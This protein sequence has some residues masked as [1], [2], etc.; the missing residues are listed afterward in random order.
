AFDSAS[1]FLCGKPARLERRRENQEVGPTGRGWY[2]P[3][4]PKA[5][6]FRSTWLIIGYDAGH[7]FLL[8]FRRRA[9]TIPPRNEF[10][11]TGIRSFR[12]PAFVRTVTDPTRLA[13]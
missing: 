8:A 3:M 13:M 12:L 2:H 9:V 11:L 10:L 5:W 4:A 6:P 7:G 1:L